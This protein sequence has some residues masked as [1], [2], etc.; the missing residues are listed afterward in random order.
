[1]KV[2]MQNSPQKLAMRGLMKSILR[3]EGPAGFYK[4]LGPPLVTVPM[5]NSIIFASYEFC[6]RL[7]GVKSQQDFTFAQ[8]MYCGMFAGLVNS[9]VLSPIELVKCRL[10]I[11]SESRQ[12]AYYKGSVDCLVKICREEGL[13]NGLFKGMLST[14]LR[15]VPCYA[16]QFGAYYAT[17]QIISKAKGVDESQLTTFDLFVSGGVGG[18]FCWLFSYP[19]DIIKTNL[20]V[21]RTVAYPKYQLTTKSGRV[22][23]LPDGGMTNC[24]LAIHRSQGWAGFWRGFSACSA[25]A[26]IANSFMFAA[27]EYAQGQYREAQENLDVD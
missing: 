4:G 24:A 3:R 5:I 8:S 9:F 11:Q 6:K 19:Q 17:K 20:Q 25:R 23:L 16:G 7:L 22:Y 15:E 21:A 1:M 14:V 2:R 13:R 12:N 27:Y 10:Q 18:F 26:V